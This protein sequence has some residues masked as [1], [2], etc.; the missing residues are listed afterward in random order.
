[1]IE[2]LN[3]LFSSGN[4][5]IPIALQNPDPENPN[6]PYYKQNVY[7][8]QIS[9]MMRAGIRSPQSQLRFEAAE[10]P[11]VPVSPEVQQ[12]KQQQEMLKRYA[13]AN[14]ARAGG[15]SATIPGAMGA[16]GQAPQA[17]PFGPEAQTMPMPGY[18][19]SRTLPMEEI[20]EDEPV[21]KDDLDKAMFSG[22]ELPELYKLMM[23]D[24]ALNLANP[25]AAPMTREAAGYVPTGIETLIPGAST[26]GVDFR[27][28]VMN[29]ARKRLGNL[30][31]IQ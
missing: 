19:P 9:P 12:A 23:T 29:P 18:T 10:K 26:M 6:S 15:R 24:Y 17:M 3:N 22:D 13:M 5:Q 11:A 7:E 31:G 30:L 21:S 14:M 1:M 20:K 28:V 27:N 16:P 4:Q 8:R 25:Q 2:F